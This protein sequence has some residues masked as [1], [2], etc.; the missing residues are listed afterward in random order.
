MTS[1]V[2]FPEPM[3]FTSCDERDAEET[4]NS[5]RAGR[6]A[7]VSAVKEPKASGLGSLRKTRPPPRRAREGRGRRAVEISRL[8]IKFECGGCRLQW[9][10]RRYALTRARRRLRSKHTKQDP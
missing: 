2:C 7:R 3:R 1:S 4:D 5:A 10:T 6:F 9:T 8:E